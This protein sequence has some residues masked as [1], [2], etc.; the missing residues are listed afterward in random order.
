VR[1]NL[2]GHLSLVLFSAAF[3]VSSV[4]PGLT[5]APALQS[6]QA[7]GTLTANGKTHKLVHANAYI[8]QRDESKP[9]VLL[10]TDVPPPA[11]L[12]EGRFT[13]TFAQVSADTPFSGLALRMND[14]GIIRSIE[15]Y[16]K[17]EAIDI[18]GL[19]DVKFDGPFNAKAIIGSVQANAGAAKKTPP[20]QVSATFHASLK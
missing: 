11:I 8:D 13:I 4:Q 5:Q 1:R 12:F 15:Y 7:A 16:D 10:L 17:D 9:L 20:L 14:R 19:L 2:F 6:G 3:V 18:S